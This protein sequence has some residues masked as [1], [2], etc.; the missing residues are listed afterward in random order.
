MTK[1]GNQSELTV[2]K[3]LWRQKPQIATKGQSPQVTPMK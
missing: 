3:L 1:N 2:N